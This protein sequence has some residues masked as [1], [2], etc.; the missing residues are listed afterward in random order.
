MQSAKSILAEIG[1]E[2]IDSWA[3]TDRKKY[4]FRFDKEPTIVKMLESRGL[5]KEYKK[6]E[7]TDE[8]NL[9]LTE[10]TR[11]YFR[12]IDWDNIRAEKRDFYETEHSCWWTPEDASPLGL[13]ARAV[14]E[15]LEGKTG[16]S[17]L[18]DYYTWLN[19][20]YPI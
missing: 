8:T 19:P 9:V 17:R 13:R 5:V 20:G 15:F 10:H 18:K 4:T 16:E 6:G 2:K 12:I 14:E 11:Y 7:F 3:F 1:F